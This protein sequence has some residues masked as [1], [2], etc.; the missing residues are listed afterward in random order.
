MSSSIFPGVREK[1]NEMLAA[2]W[3][4]WIDNPL[5]LLGNSTPRKAVRAPDGREIVESIII[6]AER[7]ENVPTDPAVFRRLC[8]QLG[9]GGGEEGR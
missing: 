1:L 6:E 9:L 8:D 2:K 7:N 3:E 4:G 5:R